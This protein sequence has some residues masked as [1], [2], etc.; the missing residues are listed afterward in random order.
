[1]HKHPD[2]ASSWEDEEMH[3]LE[4]EDGVFVV[5]G[6]MCRSQMELAAKDGGTGYVIQKDTVGN[7]FARV[8]RDTRRLLY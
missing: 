3:R 1:M 2:G 8:G 5:S 7:Q 6:P 4:Q